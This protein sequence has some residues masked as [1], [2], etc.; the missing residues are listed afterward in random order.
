MA[1]VYCWGVEAGKLMYPSMFGH[2]PT[3]IYMSYKP[4]ESFL[5]K[6]QRK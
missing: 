2:V 4:Y 5:P 6:Q 1:A 3:S